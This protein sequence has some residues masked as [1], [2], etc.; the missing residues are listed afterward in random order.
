MTKI[1]KLISLSLVLIM[2]FAVMTPAASAVTN[3]RVKYPIIFIA[4]S[5]VDLVDGDQKPISTGFDVFTDD[6]EGDLT[7]DD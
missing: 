3:D 6:D 1:K 5:S 4:G 2:L 7:K